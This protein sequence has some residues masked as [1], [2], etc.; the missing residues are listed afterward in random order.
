MLK[1][2]KSNYDLIADPTKLFEFLFF[3][4]LLPKCLIKTLLFLL[5][6]LRFLPRLQ[7][8][9]VL[10]VLKKHSKVILKSLDLQKDTLCL[11]ISMNYKLVNQLLVPNQDQLR[12]QSQYMK[13]KY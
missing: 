8:H 3:K 7:S 2:Q 5:E 6:I 1:V 11:Q 12:Q 4:H 10:L 13:Y 9:L